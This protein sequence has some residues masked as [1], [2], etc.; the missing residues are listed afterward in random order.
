MFFSP[1]NNV[2]TGPCQPRSGSVLVVLV[3]AA[4]PHAALVAPLGS[5]IEP[6]VRAPEAVHAAR[7]GGVGVVN[8]AAFERERAEARPVA[9]VRGHVGSGHGRDLRDGSFAA[10][11]LPLL[12]GLSGERLRSR[13]L[14][15]IIVLDVSLALL[16]LGEPDI[17]VGVEVAAERRRPRE[18]PPH[19]L[20]ESVQLRER[21]PRDRPQHDVMVRQVDGKAIEAVRDH[22]AG[23][24]ARLVI[25]P[26]HKMVDE[27]LRAAS[28]KVGQ[29]GIPFIGVEAVR[30]VDPHPRQL[31]P[32][33]RQFVAPP[34][35]L[36]LCIEQIEPRRE[37]V[38]TCPGR[39]CGHR[40]SLPSHHHA[41]SRR[42]Y[43]AL[44]R[45]QPSQ[46]GSGSVPLTRATRTSRCMCQPAPTIS[47][48]PRSGR[49]RW[50]TV[51]STSLPCGSSSNETSP[52][53][54]HVKTSLRGGWTSVIRLCMRCSSEKPDGRSPGGSVS[55]LL[56][57]T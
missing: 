29:R 31:L 1:C 9:R 34:R 14:A 24:A 47:I 49:R 56:R 17:E 18:R 41:G 52:L 10:A 38:F 19:P 28:E 8:N 53:F 57:Q 44:R 11:E 33:A 20:L 7:I 21:R 42:S 3:V 27:E 26:E 32:P 43:S 23:G 2:T 40:S 6:L 16:L 13:C 51:S 35:K 5:A 54:P 4:P 46:N 30:L 39:V 25:R 50:I 22:R 37:P 36:L 45:L 12:N 55:S 15:L 48:V